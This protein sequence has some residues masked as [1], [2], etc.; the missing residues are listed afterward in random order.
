MCT[1]GSINTSNSFVLIGKVDVAVR[2]V[3]HCHRIV[4]IGIHGQSAV[5]RVALDAC[6]NNNTRRARVEIKLFDFMVLLSYF[7]D[8]HELRV[9]IRDRHRILACKHQTDLWR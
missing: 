8:E 4:D 1:C 2:I 9:V 3:A 6:T 7:V 5:T